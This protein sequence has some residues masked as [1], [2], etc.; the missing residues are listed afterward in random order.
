MNKKRILVIDDEFAVLKITQVSLKLTR[1]WEVLIAESGREGLT[2]A[3]AESL[4]AILLDVMMPEMDALA[5]LQELQKSPHLQ[6]IP[7]ILLTATAEIAKQPQYAQL[8]AKAILIKPFDPEL[9]PV[10]IETALGWS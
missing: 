5:T 10:Q 2:I 8:G 1:Q 9:L 4:D 6:N 7:V 3:A